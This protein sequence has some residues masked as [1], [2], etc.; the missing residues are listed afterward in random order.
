[1]YICY[2]TCRYIFRNCTHTMYSSIGCIVQG[3]C[4]LL[5]IAQAN[6]HLTNHSGGHAPSLLSVYKMRGVTVYVQGLHPC[7]EMC[8]TDF[9]GHGW[10]SHSVST[11]HVVGN[12]GFFVLFTH[13]YKSIYSHIS[14]CSWIM[15]RGREGYLSLLGG[16]HG[17]GYIYRTCSL[18]TEL[19]W[20]QIHN[21]F[22]SSQYQ[23]HLF[24]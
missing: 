17:M 11:D 22:P 6:I 12:I 21:H 16:R 10:S 20:R 1:M 24:C 19:E 4:K 14:E 5:F 18:W 7:Q 3:Q 9:S 2:E 23:L 15:Y 13:L 8:K